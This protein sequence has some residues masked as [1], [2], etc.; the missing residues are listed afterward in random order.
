MALGKNNVEIA[1][2]NRKKVKK[3]N[4]IEQLLPIGSVVLLKNGKKKIMII[5]IKQTDLTTNT[6]YDYLAIP[7]PEGFV[8]QECMFFVNHEAIQEISFRGYDDDERKQFIGKLADY[9][10]NK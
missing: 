2:N 1:D 7:Y 5:G 10:K 6:V 9:Y 3:M 4:N 8:S